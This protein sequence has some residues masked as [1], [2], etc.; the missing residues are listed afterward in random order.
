MKTSGQLGLNL[1][2]NRSYGKKVENKNKE[3][4]NKLDFHITVNFYQDQITLLRHGWIDVM[5][6]VKLTHL[7]KKN[8]LIV[9]DKFPRHVNSSS[10]NL[11]I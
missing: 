11:S 3:K 1:Y 8:E 10:L 2:G 6:K 4:K 9:F 7:Y 5:N